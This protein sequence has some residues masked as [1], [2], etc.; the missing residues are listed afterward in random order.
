MYFLP[1][2]SFDFGLPGWL[3]SQG[4][5]ARNIT[6]LKSQAAKLIAG[7]DIQGF[8]E[9]V[10]IENNYVNLDV[11]GVG[12]SNDKWVGVGLRICQTASAIFPSKTIPLFKGRVTKT[13]VSVSS[14]NTILLLQ[15]RQNGQTMDVRMGTLAIEDR[16][17]GASINIIA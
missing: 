12:I 9:G 6:N 7:V 5:G 17:G 16:G 3:G 4:Q 15:A 13:A 11:T 10:H 2:T 8:S 1:A 14:L